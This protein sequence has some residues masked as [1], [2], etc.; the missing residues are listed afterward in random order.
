[1]WQVAQLGSAMSQM[2]LYKTSSCGAVFREMTP[3]ASVV[4]SLFF[5]E[6]V[7]PFSSDL[8]IARKGGVK[9]EVFERA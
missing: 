8:V 7:S 2:W 5:L 6:N 3:F 9:N 1:M 4:E